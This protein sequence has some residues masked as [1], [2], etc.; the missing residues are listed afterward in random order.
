MLSEAARRE[1][2]ARF[3]VAGLESTFD[4]PRPYGGRSRDA[5]SGRSYGVVPC[6]NNHGVD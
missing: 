1:L 3:S 5:V 4:P 6:L 2:Y